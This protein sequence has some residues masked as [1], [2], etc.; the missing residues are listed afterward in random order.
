MATHPLADHRAKENVITRV[1]STLTSTT[2]AVPSSA[3]DKEGT[4]C[5]VMR[6]VCLVCAAYTASVLDNAFGRLGY[7]EREAAFGRADDILVEF[8]S[9]P[10]G[11]A[12]GIADSGPKRKYSNRIAMGSSG[13][14]SRESILGFLSDVKKES[15]G[16]EEDLGFEL[17][18]GVLEVLSKLDSLI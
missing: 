4:Q 18:A 10:F 17:I 15:V 11:S 16:G 1:I 14:G 2:S 7:E 6:A 5:R 8:S 13:D 3:L 12:T 9:W